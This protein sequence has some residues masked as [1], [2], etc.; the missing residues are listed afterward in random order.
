MTVPGRHTGDKLYR[1]GHMQLRRLLQAEEFPGAFT[2]APVV[3]QFSSIGALGSKKE[4][5]KW[6]RE[7]AQSFS[8]G[9][10]VSTGQSLGL[11]PLQIVWPSGQEVRESF[12]GY[13]AGASIPGHSDKLEQVSHLLHLWGGKP[14]GRKRAAPHIKSY[15][16][17]S[18]ALLLHIAPHKLALKF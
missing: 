17:Y 4:P 2:D 15:C 6:L 8:A 10:V 16:R 11:A 7:V 5:E 12:E 1:F 3:A 18:G 14:A 9:R 13:C